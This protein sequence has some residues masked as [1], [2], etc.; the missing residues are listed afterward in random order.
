MLTIQPTESFTGVKISGDYWDID[1]LLTAI[2]AVCGDEN[3]YYDFQGSRQRLVAT[4][5]KLR[6]AIRAEHHI[7][8]VSNGIHK[9]VKH[10][11]KLLAPEKNVYFAV[12]ILMPEVFFTA[13]ALNDYIDLHHEMIDAS[14][15]N[16][17]VAVIRHFQGIVSDLLKDLIE[18]E[19]FN[20]FIQMLHTKRPLFFRYATQYV[21]MLNLEYIALSIEER[22][23]SLA[24]YILRFFMEDEGYIVLHE[25]LMS[26]AV[27]TKLPL[28]NLDLK[29]NYPDEI[30][31]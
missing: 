29:L 15:W 25:Q 30:E 23:K 21:D 4:C 16:V 3:R 12:E 27:E 9:G 17:H 31:W 28:H 20:I 8:F 6:N 24:A 13:M 5:L 26:V 1:E 22:H 19:H 14:Q 11:K 2:Y 10:S 7:E 18:E